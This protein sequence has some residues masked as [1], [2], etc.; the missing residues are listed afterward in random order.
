VQED[1]RVEEE[2]E[3]VE[4]SDE[5]TGLG[6]FGLGAASG[7]GASSGAGVASGV[8]AALDILDDT[9]KLGIDNVCARTNFR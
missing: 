7:A 9:R 4:P 8:G 5:F 1:E 2:V 3:E 6:A